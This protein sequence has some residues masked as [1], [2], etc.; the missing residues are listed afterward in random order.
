MNDLNSQ[1]KA[2]LLH[3]KSRKTLEMDRNGLIF[4]AIVAWN[5]LPLFGH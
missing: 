2:F 5:S 3:P 4:S 1:R